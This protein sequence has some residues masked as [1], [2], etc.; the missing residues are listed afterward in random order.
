MIALASDFDG[1]LLF[2][3]NIKQQDIIK[4]KEFQK[5][6]NLFG[7]CSGRPLN[8]LSVHT[9]N[10][11]DYDFMI[12]STGAM[13]C[14]G[15]NEII[16]KQCIPLEIIKQIHNTYVD[17]YDV[18]IQAN[19]DMYKIRTPNK[20]SE[21]K[22]SIECNSIDEIKGDIYG[23]CIDTVNENNA[24]LLVKEIK[25]NYPQVEPYQNVKDIDIV[26]SGVSKGSGIKFYKEYTKLKQIAGIGD[27]YNDMPMLKQVDISFTFHHSPKEVKLIANYIVSSVAEAIDILIKNNI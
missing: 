9:K 23:L 22:F 21:D 2:N 24:K 8:G 5:K 19:G 20:K 25:Q 13:I 4:I 11:I 15:T 12:V 10:I 3:S 18:R 16:Y 26:H 7:V 27:S 14:K 1:T 6:G 17:K